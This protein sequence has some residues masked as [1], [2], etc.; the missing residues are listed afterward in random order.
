M[1]EYMMQN[2]YDLIDAEAMNCPYTFDDLNFDSMVSHIWATYV[3][4]VPGT[5]V[6]IVDDYAKK[7]VDDPV[8]AAKL[9]RA[10]TVVA[11][12][13]SVLERIGDSRFVI[14][15]EEGDGKTYRAVSGPAVAAILASGTRF[16]CMIH[17]WEEDGTHNIA[18]V[19][20]PFP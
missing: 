11:G 4:R 20:P 2:H 5:G 9:R 17:P 14:R 19:V 18:A 12:T 13:F 3:A 1:A 7:H 6:R 8:F 10:T 16:L 15:S